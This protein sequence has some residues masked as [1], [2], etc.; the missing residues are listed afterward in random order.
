MQTMQETMSY[1]SGRTHVV[2][3]SFHQLSPAALESRASAESP[4]QSPSDQKR[5]LMEHLPMVRFV[6]IRIHKRVPQSVDLEDLVSAGLLGL[7]EAVVKFDSAKKIPFAGYAQFRVRGAILDSLRSTD[8]APRSMRHK[9]R[10]VQEA[11]RVLSERL[12]HAP[13]EEEV[14]AELKMSLNSYQKLLGELKGLEIG[15]LQRE[16]KEDSGESDEID[17]PTRREDDPLFRCLQGQMQERLTVAIEDLPERERQVLTLYYYEE[18]SRGEISMLLNLSDTR[19]QQIRTSAILH[20]RSALS[21]FCSKSC[22]PMGLVRRAAGKTPQCALF[23]EI[24][25]CA[26]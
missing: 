5:V 2:A 10:A 13:S 9:G 23:S 1:R 3:E 4:L 26:A 24:A 15:S 16:C 21:D 6:A 22:R 14:A 7:M 8:W 19:V 11:I 12:R 20:L 25:G 17:I 18:L